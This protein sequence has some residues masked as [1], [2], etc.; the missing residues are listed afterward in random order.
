MSQEIILHQWEISPFCQKV[1]RALRYKGL[2]YSTVDYNGLL[3]TKVMRLS[4]V[5]KVPVL[6]V[7]GE[8]IQDSTRIVRWLDEHYPK[9]ALYPSSAKQR[10]L[11]DLWEDWSDELLY[12][13]EVHFRANDPKALK[14]AVRLSCVGRPAAERVAVQATLKLTLNAQ[15]K[16]QGLGR[17]SK[18]DIRS[19]FLGLLDRVET[20]LQ[21]SG[22][23]VGKSMTVADIAVG[24]QFLEVER[25]SDS[26][27]PELWKRPKLAAMLERIKA[28]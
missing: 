23:L 15:L 8:R 1:A 25:T 7:D 11:V 12:W 2:E 5:G 14:E 26:M 18:E 9:P 13:Y 6:E 3:G 21:P 10:A 22:W 4:K 19:S 24:S 16:S 28:I 20:S 27:R 17:M